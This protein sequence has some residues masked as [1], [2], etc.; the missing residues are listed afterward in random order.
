MCTNNID[1]VSTLYI[2]YGDGFSEIEK[3]MASHTIDKT[4]FSVKI[5]LDN[6]RIIK[7]LRFDPIENRI[8]RCHIKQCL[9][10]GRNVDAVAVNSEGD[11][12]L[13]FTIDPQF[14]ILIGEN[15]YSDIEISGIF[16]YVS[17]N[18]LSALYNDMKIRMN[19]YIQENSRMKLD[20]EQQ[21]IQEYKDNIEEMKHKQQLLEEEISRSRQDNEIV[22]SDNEVLRAENSE[23]IR[24]S[25]IKE[26][27][28]E[29]LQKE[30]KE[31]E[32]KYDNLL[33][34]VDR[35][36]TQV[37]HLMND[38]VHLFINKLRRK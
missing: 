32:K 20:K 4:E 19:A 30:F 24:I 2:D 25:K 37:E 27:E 3:Q 14:L 16:Y 6:T 23:I 17:D 36:E 7:A 29:Q 31:A 5:K 13:F 34:R 21:K 35:L 28:N 38:R 10:D 33:I 9:L 22:S 18:E 1:I 15:Y 11:S 12:D 26:K 8:C